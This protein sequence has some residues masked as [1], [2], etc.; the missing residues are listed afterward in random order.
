[1]LSA[2]ILNP[3]ATLNDF[4]I[5]DA[6]VFIPGE[7]TKLVMRLVQP[8]RSDELRYI[9]VDTADLTVYL[10]NKDG[11]DLELTMTVFDDDRSIWYSTLTSAQTEEL[12]SG[13]FTFDL[14]ILG[15]GTQI[16]K[17]WV[18]NGLSLQITGAC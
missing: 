16:E 7:Q 15:D 18:E 3:T 5:I 1:M 13:N 11:T 10:K 2:K 12:A 17:G 6:L 8:F 14:D 9:P 4:D